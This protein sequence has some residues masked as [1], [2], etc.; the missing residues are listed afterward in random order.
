MLTLTKAVTVG[1]FCALKLPQSGS[2]LRAQYH[3]WTDFFSPRQ[4]VAVTSILES[5][6]ATCEL[7]DKEVKEQSRQDAIKTYIAI[8]VD[9]CVDYD[10]RFTRFDGTRNKICNKFDKHN[11]AFK[12]SYAEFDAAHILCPWVLD[13]AIDAYSGIMNL[14]VPSSNLLTGSDYRRQV[15]R[16][17]FSQGPAQ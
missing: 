1:Q 3:T 2:I 11:Y 12:W 5:F 14:A 17:T 7:I 8:A 9:K 10:C 6:F 4:K 13:Q 15:D 16:L